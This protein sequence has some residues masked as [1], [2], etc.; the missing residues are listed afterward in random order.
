MGEQIAR[1]VPSGPRRS[2][3]FFL[4]F[5]RAQNFLNDFF[6]QITIGFNNGEIALASAIL[7]KCDIYAFSWMLDNRESNQSVIPRQKTQSAHLHTPLLIRSF[8]RIESQP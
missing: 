8:Q 2:F 7:W 1:T 6:P 3:A 4:L 5:E